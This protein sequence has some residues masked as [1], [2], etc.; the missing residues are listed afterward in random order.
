ML[1]EIRKVLKTLGNYAVVE[2]L[3]C[4]SQFGFPVSRER[5]YIL[6]ITKDLLREDVALCSF[7]QSV[8][9]SMKSEPAMTFSELLFEPTHKI[10]KDYMKKEKFG[11]VTCNAH[12]SCR[13]HRKHLA[14][15]P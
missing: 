12:C 11:E 15:E 14:L 10:V 1:P 3:L 13:G 5:Y 4:P 6:L 7:V 9:D 8:V 2:L